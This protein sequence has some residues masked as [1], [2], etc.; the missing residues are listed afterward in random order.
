VVKEL[1]FHNVNMNLKDNSGLT[2]FDLC[3]V[4]NYLF[5]YKKFN[6]FPK[7]FKY[8]HIDADKELLKY[9]ANIDVK[10]ES[11]RTPLS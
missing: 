1:I 7:A 3:I 8:D 6:F 11:G 4:L 9:N 10:D 2:S 5:N